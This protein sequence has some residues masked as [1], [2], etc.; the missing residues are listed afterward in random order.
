MPTPDLNSNDY[1]AVLGCNRN[2]SDA[3]LKKAYRKLAVKWHPDKNPDNEEATKK[4]QTIS[5]AYA[6]LSDEKKRKMYDQY[7]KEGANAADNM[8]DGMGGCG[9][10]FPAGFHSAGNRGG[11]MHMSQEEAQAFFGNMF[12]SDDPFGGMFPGGGGGN[13]RMQMGGM[14]GGM[15]LFSGMF[16][17]NTAGGSMGAMGGMPPGFAGMPSG[18]SGMPPGFPGMPQQAQRRQQQRYDAISPGTVISLKGLISQPE[19]NGDQGIIREYNPVKGRYVIILEDSD[20]TMSVKASNI[21]QHVHVRIHDVK[22]QPELN[23]KSGT[24]LTWIPNKERYNIHV[25]ALKKI[26]SLRPGNVVLETG[27][28][29]QISGLQSKPELNGKWATIKAWIRDTNKYDIQLS[30]QQIIRIK[31]E[32]LRV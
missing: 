11:G 8:P 16:G 25:S 3:Q 31:V 9:G 32:N 10:G 23:G 15:D 5:E 28:V 19:R 21:L 12:G 26:V 17:G 14:P 27:T 29:G 4:F 22:S 7:G 20:E 18:F 24:I 30:E 13:V 6:V 2:A 1:Y